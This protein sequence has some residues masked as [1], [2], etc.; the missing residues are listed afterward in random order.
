MNV[1]TSKDIACHIAGTVSNGIF[2]TMLAM[3]TRLS[4][5]DVWRRDHQADQNEGMLN[6]GLLSK[7][8]LA[9]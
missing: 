7:Y 6:Q 1:T 2:D 8:L 9:T 3:S 4:Q 5:S